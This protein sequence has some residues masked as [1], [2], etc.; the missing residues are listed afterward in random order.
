M[1]Q[2]L[3]VISWFATIKELICGWVKGL[4]LLKHSLQTNIGM[5][6]SV[7]VTL[8]LMIELIYVA[9]I[10]LTDVVFVC[11]MMETLFITLIGLP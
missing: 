9:Y 7:F 4:Y 8:C 11:V 10:N 6:Q 5:L 2:Q 1:I 3:N